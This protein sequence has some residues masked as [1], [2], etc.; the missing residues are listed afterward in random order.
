MEEV[1]DESET[2]EQLSL[3]HVKMSHWL[4]SAYNIMWACSPPTLKH[5]LC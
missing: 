1:T 3:T 4:Q 2:Q 5:V